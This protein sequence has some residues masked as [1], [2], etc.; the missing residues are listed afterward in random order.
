MDLP[1]RDGLEEYAESLDLSL[2]DILA[3][4]EAALSSSEA[5]PQTDG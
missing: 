5:A 2:K 1:M 3:L 4:L